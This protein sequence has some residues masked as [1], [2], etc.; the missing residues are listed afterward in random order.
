M[1]QRFKNYGWNLL[2]ALDQLANTILF[3]HPDETFSARTYRKALAGQRFWIVLRGLIDL[4]F[5]WE[6]VE[7]CREAYENEMNRAQCPREYS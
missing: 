4:A 7:H 1:W 2:T 5:R 6:S 3:G